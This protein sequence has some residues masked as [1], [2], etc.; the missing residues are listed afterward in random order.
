MNALVDAVFLTN[1]SRDQALECIAHLREPEIASVVVVDN[2]SGDDTVEAVRASHPDVTVVALTTLSGISAALNHGAE[3]GSAPFV[4]YLNDDVFAVPGSIGLLVDTL[5]ARPEAVAAGGRLVEHDLT[6]QDR[7]RPRAFPSPATVVA[8]VLGL[9]RLWARNPLTGAHLRRKLDDH[10]TV[11]VDQPAGA[12]LLVRRPIVERV[13]GWDERYWFWYED[14]DF[15]RRLAEHGDQ[16][17]VPAA[18][19]RHIGGSTVRRMRRAESHRS[20]FHGIVVYA[21][22]HFTR[23]GRAVVGL[24]LTAVG[25]ARSL[26]SAPTDREAARIYAAT[27]RAGLALLAGR[28]IAGLRD[29]GVGVQPRALGSAG[30]SVRVP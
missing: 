16:L 25:A 28:P 12:C 11:V 1:S 17:Y 18:P 23:P 3:I 7:Y 10:T 19:F 15:S 22:T 5:R 6:T 21:Q 9:E 29:A 30:D 2:A 14:V 8:R 4:L 24:S 13:G 26:T 20:T 27:A